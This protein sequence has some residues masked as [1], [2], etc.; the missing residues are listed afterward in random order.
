[1][2]GCGREQLHG[3]YHVSG[4]QVI[5][6]DSR[7]ALQCLLCQLPALCTVLQLR[8][9]R[10]YGPAP[11]LQAVLHGRVGSS[12]TGDRQT[13]N[14]AGYLASSF[15]M[16]G[17]DNVCTWLLC[18][19]PRKCVVL[20]PDGAQDMPVVADAWQL[21]VP[22]TFTGPAATI[23]AWSACWMCCMLSLGRCAS[24]VHQ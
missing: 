24:K 17:G 3:L 13:V 19:M 15:V 6:G 9:L 11:A 1:M 7:P 22:H 4:H 18:C 2:T 5:V 16:F 21:A 23:T 8:M 14:A 20:W 10:Q 12:V